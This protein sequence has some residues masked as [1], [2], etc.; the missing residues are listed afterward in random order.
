MQKVVLQGFISSAKVVTSGVPQGSVLGPSL[1]LVYINDITECVS[2][3]LRLFADDAL[4]FSTLADN[5]SIKQFQEDLDNL[6]SWSTKYAMSFNTDKCSMIFFGSNNTV[7]QSQIQYKLC[8]KPLKVE[9]AIK[10]LGITITNNLKWE[11]HISNIVNKS[12]R[13]LGLIKSILYCAPIKVK[14]IAYLTLCR[15]LL[16]FASDLWDPYMKK[17]ITSIEM[18]QHR[19]IRFILN[20]KGIVSITE[21]REK[22]QLETLE[23]RRLRSR[24]HTLMKILS[25]ADI[26]SLL[27]NDL[28]NMMSVTRNVTSACTT[29]SQSNTLPLSLYTRTNVFYNSFLP[30]TARDLRLL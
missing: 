29:R 12:Y 7:N 25:N 6:Q 27:S 19:A 28:T 18:V 3:E 5:N 2:S 23:E 9:E 14:K 15:P 17:D 4:M 24:K 30:R 8:G 11:T 1:F 16:E 22:L 13:T 26:H 10:Y 20:L 21:G